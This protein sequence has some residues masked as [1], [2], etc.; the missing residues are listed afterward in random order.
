MEIIIITCDAFQHVV[1]LCVK[2]LQVAWDGCADGVTVVT[3]TQARGTVE[4]QINGSIRMVYFLG[5]DEGW[6]NN[7]IKYLNESGIIHNNKPFLLLLEDYIIYDINWKTL[8]ECIDT[9]ETH[10]DVGMIRLVP[11]PG[12]ALPWNDHRGRSKVIGKLDKSKHESYCMSLQAALWKPKTLLETLEPDLNPWKTEGRGSRRIAQGKICRHT[13]FMCTYDKVISYKNLLRRGKP[14][15]GVVDW[16]RGQGEDVD[17][18]FG[19]TR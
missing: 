17:A 15:K 10:D 9:I 5:P 3:N 12:P 11:I 6:S 2:F 13:D 14:D 7:M 18:I 4:L 8:R 19:R 16:L 1:P